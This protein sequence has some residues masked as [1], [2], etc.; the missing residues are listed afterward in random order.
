M[1]WKWGGERGKGGRAEVVV[2]VAKSRLNHLEHVCRSNEL[3]VSA[4]L[5]VR[6]TEGG[7]GR[8]RRGRGGRGR[9][10]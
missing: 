10:R 7:A 3:A 1:W 9:V 4:A 6:M 2:A 5:G 8:D